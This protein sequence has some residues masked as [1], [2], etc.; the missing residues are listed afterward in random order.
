MKK[1]VA[2]LLI[3][4]YSG[5]ALGGVAIN[6]HYCHGQLAKIS[7]LNF[8]GQKGCGCNPQDMPKDC[9]K[10]ELKYQKS[11]DHRTIQTAQIADLISFAVEPPPFAGYLILSLFDKG[12]PG[13]STNEVWRS[14][15]EPI[16][17]L[18]SVFRI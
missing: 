3:L 6:L 2:I 18:N 10:D 9:C 5:I 8:G 13:Y 14:N 4:I 16:Y 7:I 15:P 11:D 1:L 12:D 17:L